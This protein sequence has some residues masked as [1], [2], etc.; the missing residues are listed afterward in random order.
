MSGRRLV[1]D[2]VDE[3]AFME[4]DLLT[5]S[6]HQLFIFSGKPRTLDVFMK[7]RGDLGFSAFD[8]HEFA[9]RSGP[10]HVQYQPAMGQT[11][12][13]WYDGSLIW[14]IRASSEEQESSGYKFK[15]KS[16][17]IT[18]VLLSINLRSADKDNKD[19]ITKS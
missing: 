5:L 19:D 6:S 1:G 16:I 10:E 3:A 2:L 13:L 8:D 18:Y 9:A 17:C 11:T 12:R 14:V 15:T 7:K 4:Y